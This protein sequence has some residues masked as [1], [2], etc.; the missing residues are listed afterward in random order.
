MKD[1][2]EY[3]KEMKNKNNRVQELQVYLKQWSSISKF[4]FI[5]FLEFLRAE[6]VKRG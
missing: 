2:D 1:I 3:L 6:A 5:T 4:D